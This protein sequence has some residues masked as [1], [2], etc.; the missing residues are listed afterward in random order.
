MFKSII[1]SLVLAS[2]LVTPAMAREYNA[3]PLGDL[4]GQSRSSTSSAHQSASSLPRSSYRE[5]HTREQLT[6]AMAAREQAVRMCRRGNTNAQINQVL[7]EGG[8]QLTGV[9]VDRL[10]NGRR[11]FGGYRNYGNVSSEQDCDAIGNAVYQDALTA[12]LDS[13][14][15]E[16]SDEEY[17]RGGQ[18]VRQERM[19]RECQA[20]RSDTQW[21]SSFQP[22]N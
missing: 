3:Y 14:C 15:R 7:I 1:S 18:P 20:I 10:V 17:T 12:Q 8:T 22:R 6:F 9:L 16:S 19:R 5:G 11:S 21:N 4:S 2:A 13:Y